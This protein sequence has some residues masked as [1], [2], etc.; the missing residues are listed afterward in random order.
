[1]RN[2]YVCTHLL[3]AVSRTGEGGLKR[4]AL[5][6]V[7]VDR[8]ARNRHVHNRLDRFTFLLMLPNNRYKS[9]RVPVIS[10]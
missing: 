2:V 3:I 6:T 9:I 1:M 7:K 5:K 4:R 10:P 8:D